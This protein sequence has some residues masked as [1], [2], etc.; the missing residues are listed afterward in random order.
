MDG[1]GITGRMQ[2]RLW[3]EAFNTAVAWWNVTRRR[4]GKMA[5]DELWHG[6]MPRWTK[7][8]RMF[9]E[10]GVI[11]RH[12]LLQKLKNKGIDAMCLGHQEDSAAGVYRMLNLETMRVNITRD[13]KWMNMTY[14]EYITEVQREELSEGSE[15]VED[16]DDTVGSESTDRKEKILNE[17]S[18]DYEDEANSANG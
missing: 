5:P 13:V 14:G 18:V 4:K 2:G 17:E 11:K 7:R 8:P 10:I 3:A 12:G 9:G 16:D 1:A 15:L 6:E